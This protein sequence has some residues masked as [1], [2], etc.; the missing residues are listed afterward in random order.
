MIT[1]ETLS[2][3]SPALFEGEEDE[4]GKVDKESPDYAKINGQGHY[5][6]K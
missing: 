4:G 2:P 1:L 5:Y 3:V 6:R